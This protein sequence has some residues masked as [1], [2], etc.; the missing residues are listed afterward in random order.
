MNV[1]QPSEGHRRLS[2]ALCVIECGMRLH[3]NY[4]E[5]VTIIRVSSAVY[6]SLGLTSSVKPTGCGMVPVL[7]RE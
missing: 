3:G 7:G 6:E 4:K 1:L 5:V 2:C